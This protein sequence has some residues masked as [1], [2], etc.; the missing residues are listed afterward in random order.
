MKKL[1]VMALLAVFSLGAFAQFEQGKWYVSTNLVGAGLSYSGN[2]KLAFGLGAKG[3]YFFE[4]DWMLTAEGGMDFR[5]SDFRSMW[6]G[7]GCRYYIEQ[8]G[9]WLAASGKLVHEFKSYNDFMITPEIGYCFFVNRYITL[10]PSLYFDIST[11]DFSEYSRVGVKF[12]LGF[13]F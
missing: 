3:G 1:F 9:L 12:G 11:N 7:A 10:E 5:D 4:R 2:D 13:Y 8:N 6:V